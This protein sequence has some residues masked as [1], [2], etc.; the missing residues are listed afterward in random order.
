MLT[1]LPTNPVR[2]ASFNPNPNH[3]ILTSRGTRGDRMIGIR[4][5]V[6]KGLELR[7]CR[8]RL[9]FVAFL[10]GLFLTLTTA[11]F[12]QECIGC[13]VGNPYASPL[14]R[15]L[16]PSSAADESS[17]T[18][19]TRVNEVMVFFTAKKGR[20]YVDDLAL[21]DV[22][23]TEDRKPPKRISLFGRQSD[24]PLRLGLLLDASDSIQRRLR[25][26]Q[27]SSERFLRDV[28]RPNEDQVFALAFA[29]QPF[30]L[31]DF[32]DDSALIAAS[33]SSLR[34]GGE[35]ALFDA[36]G[37]ACRRF[38]DLQDNEPVARVLILLTD[39]EDN[40]STF[41][42]AQAIQAAQAAQVT[43]YAISTNNSPV[44]GLG[45]H[46]LE[47][48]A[49]DTGGVAFFPDSAKDT[50]RAFRSIEQEMRTR[51]LIS[52]EPRDRALDGQFHTIQLTARK[53]GKKLDVH[54]RKGYYAPFPDQTSQR[55]QAGLSAPDIRSE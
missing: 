55:Q 43:I 4:G 52:Y 1:C 39:G 26:E 7:N 21:N 22:T 9:V 45:D 8:F 53:N 49:V 10:W 6:S 37:A 34:S 46:I 17:W 40:A 12:A 31:H 15:S 19:R 5:Y 32:T 24:L 28:L 18:I 2:L 38:Y 51:Y 42:L 50:I 36:I 16:T 13:S 30:L 3:P 20:K 11:P 29:D 35:T 47:R 33:I 25:F 27:D 41:T 44:V 23:V 14:H 48:L 54:A